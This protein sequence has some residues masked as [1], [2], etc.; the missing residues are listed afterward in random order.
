[1]IPKTIHQI[2]WNRLYENKFHEK[3]LSIRK[4][5]KKINP[6]YKFIIYNEEEMDNF[7]YNNFNGKIL[8]MYKKINL[9]VP[10]SDFARLLILYEIGG[11][12][13]D[14]KSSIECNLDNFITDKDKAIIS[15]ERKGW[16]EN[17]CQWAMI[18]E[19]K[20]PILEYA[21]QEIIDN[22]VNMKYYNDIEN[23]T[24]KAF[25]KAVVKFHKNYFNEVMKSHKKYNKSK[26][27][28]N[29]TYKHYKISYRIYG[30]E[31][32]N[33]IEYNKHNLNKYLYKPDSLHWRQEQKY[34][35]VLNGFFLK[36]YCNF[37]CFNYKNE[38]ILFFFI[39]VIYFKKNIK[40]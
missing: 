6:E 35:N 14:M 13:L 18:F 11:I 20:H 10:K 3:V 34:R 26:T 22:I 36:N 8:E 37:L 9:S 7:V 16:A 15:V 17:F 21:I 28:N 12:Y 33:K 39:I 19:P 30:L 32:N 25:G 24:T 5:M 1:M 4:K 2:Y 29:K 27:K 31:Y 40:K 23:M 38:I